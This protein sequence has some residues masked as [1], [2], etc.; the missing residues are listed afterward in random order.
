MLTGASGDA[1][2]AAVKLGVLLERRKKS[3]KGQRNR[4]FLGSSS[5]PHH[6]QH[7]ATPMHLF[8]LLLPVH[9]LVVSP[10][11][12]FR[13]KTAKGSRSSAQSRRSNRI[14]SNRT[15]SADSDYS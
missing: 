15:H 6:P 8:S 12:T 1:A 5:M 3:Q 14:E 10:L 11:R 2:A 9:L 7:C 13:K 4:D